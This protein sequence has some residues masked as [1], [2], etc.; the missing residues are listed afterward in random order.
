MATRTR[1]VW[2]D[3]HAGE[4]AKL[5]GLTDEDLASQAI[6]THFRWYGATMS[7]VQRWYGVTGPAPTVSE[8]LEGTGHTES[9]IRKL[10][11]GATRRVREQI[12]PLTSRQIKV[13]SAPIE[14]GQDRR[15]RTRQALL[16]GIPRP[17]VAKLRGRRQHGLVDL[18]V[19]CLAALGPLTGAQITTAIIES[20]RLRKEHRGDR[21]EDLPDVLRLAPQLT[22]DTDTDRYTLTQPVPAMSRDVEIVAELW[23]L[24]PVFGFQ[25]NRQVV[26][27]L[28]FSKA[29]RVPFVVHV[30][31]GRGRFALVDQL[32]RELR[33]RQPG[34]T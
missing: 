13:L 14:P 7:T 15:A 4:R 11:T 22:W 18:A 3:G 17:P 1:L 5:S 31:A 25:D 9:W 32:G 26:D 28:G 6:C 29:Y 19:R 2:P 12:R 10:T 34:D 27:R 23:K 33:H 21:Y 20:R 16:F 8:L 30:D 24:P